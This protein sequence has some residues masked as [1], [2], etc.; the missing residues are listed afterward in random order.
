MNK[1]P[2]EIV[3]EIS[4]YNA[5]QIYNKYSRKE[6]RHLIMKK[7]HEYADKLCEAIQEAL[8]EWDED[9]HEVFPT[10]ASVI[11]RMQPEKMIDTLLLIPMVLAYGTDWPEV[12]CDFWSNKD[13][14]PFG[15]YSKRPWIR[16]EVWFKKLE[17]KNGFDYSFSLYILTS[18]DD[19]T[20]TSWNYDRKFICLNPY[21]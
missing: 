2:E 6:N 17:E 3:A 11:E 16:S 1:L 14:P 18:D 15:Y 4:T 20:I 9:E 7:R 19:P 8:L 10:E 13:E 12:A 21:I 5:N